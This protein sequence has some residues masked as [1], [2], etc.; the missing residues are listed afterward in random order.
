[1]VPRAESSRPQSDLAL[2]LIPLWLSFH[3]IASQELA[4][5]D[6]IKERQREQQELAQSLAEEEDADF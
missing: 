2:P 5:A 1:M 4:D 3:V 6:T